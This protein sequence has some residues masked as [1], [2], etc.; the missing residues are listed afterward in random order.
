MT[1][2][3]A[4]GNLQRSV[5][6][7][8]GMSKACFISFLLLSMPVVLEIDFIL[9]I[10]L[11]DNIPNYTKIFVVI[12]IA[13]TM[14]DVF[15]PPVSFMVHATGEMKRYQLFSTIV[16]LLT[17]PVAYMFLHAGYQPHY[18]FIVAF[19]SSLIRQ[20][21]SVLI[22]CSIISIP[23]WRYVNDVVLPMLFVTIS[24]AILPVLFHWY[25]PY[26]WLRLFCVG[27]FSILSVGL[28]SY[29]IGLNIKE[30]GLV[31]QILKVRFNKN[32]E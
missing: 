11:G 27:T 9:N 28:F 18:V 7:M 17:L 30:R 21:V 2:S 15:T 8:N 1:Q 29:F 24:S 25:M 22:L 20:Y 12:I 32:I 10:W 26:G 16:N 3:Y 5:A 13:E 23:I 31:V 14:I 19:F 6:I 4:E